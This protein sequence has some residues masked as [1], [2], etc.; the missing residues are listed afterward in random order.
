MS[1][2]LSE[3]LI[4]ACIFIAVAFKH[5]RNNSTKQLIE[6]IKN[7]FTYHIVESRE[8]DEL[9]DVQAM[10]DMVL[11]NHG[12]G[13]VTCEV[14]KLGHYYEIAI[15][16]GKYQDGYYY[17]PSYTEVTGLAVPR[18]NRTD[19]N[20]HKQDIHHANIE[21]VNIVA[22]KQHQ[23]KRPLSRNELDVILKG[24]RTTNVKICYTDFKVAS[25]WIMVRLSLADNYQVTLEQ[26]IPYR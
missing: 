4:L 17:I 23:L 14:I 9:V 20:I 16:A 7:R 6:H 24:L 12:K 2:L 8:R 10:I 21:L 18:S 22:L 3:L 5:T 11:G 1:L 25:G 15:R 13:I 26:V 19:S